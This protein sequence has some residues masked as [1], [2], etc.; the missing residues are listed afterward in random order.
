MLIRASSLLGATARSGEYG[1]GVMHAQGA[2]RTDTLA[3]IPLSDPTVPSSTSFR[4]D[5]F[6]REK[7]GDYRDDMGGVGSLQRV[8][9]TLYIGRIVEESD[10]FSRPTSQGG[11]ANANRFTSAA[12]PVWKGG[13]AQSGVQKKKTKKNDD[14]HKE[15]V[16][17][18]E[19]SSGDTLA[20]LARFSEVSL[21]FTHA[22]LCFMPL[23]LIA[24]F[25]SHRHQYDSSRM[26]WMKWSTSA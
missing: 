21:C 26:R 6:G 7:H 23:T 14:E 2:G 5:I 9:R 12:G 8:N 3:R 13:A 11:G 1:S 19:R 18:T 22:C 15:E 4:R 17:G 20:S 25:I 24:F 16:S 10:N